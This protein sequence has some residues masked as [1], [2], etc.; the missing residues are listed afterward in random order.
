MKADREWYDE[1]AE[2]EGGYRRTW[3]S[4]WM[5]VSGERVFEEKLLGLL[6]PSSRVLDAGCGSGE[7]TL[8]IAALVES[9]RRRQGVLHIHGT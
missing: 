2:R 5:G 7:F 8:R 9:Q 3:E 4:Q 6:K 1:F